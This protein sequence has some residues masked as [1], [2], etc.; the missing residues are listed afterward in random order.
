MCNL[1]T[2]HVNVQWCVDL[3]M[4]NTK[5]YLNTSHVNVQSMLI[6]KLVF[7]CPYLNTSHVNVQSI[8]GIYFGGGREFKYISC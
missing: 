7:L 1:N 6:P 8:T 5:H 4:V 3:E 2:S